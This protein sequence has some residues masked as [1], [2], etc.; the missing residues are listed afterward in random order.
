MQRIFVRLLMALV[1]SMV[2]TT[3]LAAP[4]QGLRVAAERGA[5]L[6]AQA[7]TLNTQGAVWRTAG[8]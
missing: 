2:A 8:Y 4:K 7:P 1:I 5:S 3:A 6:G